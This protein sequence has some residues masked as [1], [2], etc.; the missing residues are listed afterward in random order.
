M[1][2]KCKQT[3]ISVSGGHCCY[4]NLFLSIHLSIHINIIKISPYVLLTPT[5]SKSW[6]KSHKKATPIYLLKFTY[7]NWGMITI[8]WWF[9]PYINMNLP[10]V[11]ISPPSW[12]HLPPLYPP[13]PS[14]LSQSTDFG[15]P[16]SCI[17]LALVIYFTYVNIHVSTLFSQIIP[18]SPSPT[19]SKS[20]L[21]TSVSFAVLHVRS[22]LLSF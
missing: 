1:P 21:F 12:T 5:F 6:R 7:F 16:T 14:G 8:L 2:V 4:S 20:L 10:R 17:K 9:L 3:R 19:E 22:S 11:Y 13:Y 15:C 18:P